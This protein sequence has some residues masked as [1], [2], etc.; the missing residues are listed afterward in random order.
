MSTLKAIN[1]TYPAGGFYL[2]RFFSNCN[3]MKPRANSE[4]IKL[5]LLISI[6]LLGCNL[7]LAQ[8]GGLGTSF[9]PGT[10]PDNF[11][12]STA[13]QS[14]GKIIIGGDFE[15]YNGTVRNGIARLNKDGS[16]DTSFDPGTGLSGWVSTLSIQSDGKIIIGG[17]FSSYNGTPRNSIARLNT[18]GSLDTSFDPGMG[19]DRSIYTTSIQTDGKILIGG[20]FFSY[21]G[22]ERNGIARLN[23]D[24]S[25]DTSFDPGTGVNGSVHSISLQSDGKILICGLFS[26]YNGIER[27]G[28]ARLHTDGSLDLTFDPG[29]GVDG[30]V[31]SISIQSDEKIL[32]GGF[33]GFYNGIERRGVARLHTDGSLDTSFVPGMARN[34]SVETISLQSDGKIIIGG[35]FNSPDGGGKNGVARLNSDGSFDT[36]FDPGWG[37]NT[38][39]YTISIQ[40]DGKI[41]IGGNF[42][43]YNGIS[44]NH[45][46][47]LHPTTPTAVTNP[48]EDENIVK[49]F[50]NPFSNSTSL[51]TGI[52]LKNASLTIFNSIGQLVKQITPINL[53]AGD[54]LLLN[55]DHLPGGLYFIQLSQENQIIM[56]DK[57]V[58][59]D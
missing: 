10:G 33:F 34:N 7:S 53:E 20:W 30:S 25:L 14:D 18:D 36:S 51:Y 11:I 59:S 19:P 27:R 42:Y 43:S 22:I 54:D 50:P 6:I 58:I 47:R 26:F 16:L 1:S 17:L 41:I 52:Q 21:N 44:I 2:A 15:S 46:A 5:L 9:N 35:W 49:I 55:R 57:L 45:I 48:I 4:I 31:H 3:E 56:N 8:P 32:I 38:P 24:G 39:V 13:I 28:V 12:R 37:P 29:S 23:S 40:S